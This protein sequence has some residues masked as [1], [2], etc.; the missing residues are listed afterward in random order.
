M[1]VWV[2]VH[3]PSIDG[4][5]QHPHSSYMQQVL[6]AS[7]AGF[8]QDYLH[9]ITWFVGISWPNLGKEKA[10]VSIIQGSSSEVY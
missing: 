4:W 10:V 2:S 8:A 5:Q 9:Q 6:C 7:T 1:T 3:H